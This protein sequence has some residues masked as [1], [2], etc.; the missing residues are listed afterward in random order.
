MKRS[1]VHF[2]FPPSL[3]IQSLDLWPRRP[4]LVQR[5]DPAPSDRRTAPGLGAGEPEPDHRPGG[6]LWAI[7]CLSFLWFAALLRPR[8][9][10]A[11]GGS[12]TYTVARVRRGMRRDRVRSL[13]PDGDFDAATTTTASARRPQARCTTSPTCSS[14][15]RS[16]SLI[17]F[18]AVIAVVAFRTGVLPSGGRRSRSWSPSSCDRPDRLGGAD[19][20]DAGLAARPGR[21]RRSARRRVCGSAPSRRQPHEVGWSG[22]GQ[23]RPLDRPTTPAPAA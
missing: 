10:E 1:L 13:D 3:A 7:G 4:Q 23:P 17:P 11:E 19:L 20:R 14:S 9:A 18:F 16:S 15:G 5:Q 8:L 21:P 12:H 22:R 6:W 2:S